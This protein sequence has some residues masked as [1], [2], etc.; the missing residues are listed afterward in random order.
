MR[1]D[2]SEMVNLTNHPADD[3]Y[4][5]VHPDGDRIAFHSNR[6][7]GTNVWIMRLDG[8]DQSLLTGQGPTGYIQFAPGG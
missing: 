3:E 7:G 1:S 6:L 4:P 2:G 5:D 8:S